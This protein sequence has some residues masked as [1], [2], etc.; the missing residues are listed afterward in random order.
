MRMEKSAALTPYVATQ[1]SG[2]Y[3]STQFAHPAGSAMCGLSTPPSG[4]SLSSFFF[5]KFRALSLLSKIALPVFKH[6]RTLL[7]FSAFPK[8]QGLY[9]QLLLHSLPKNTR[10][11]GYALH[12]T[13]EILPTER[14]MS[15]RINTCEK[16]LSNPSAINTYKNTRLKVER[17]QHLQK[18]GV[19]VLATLTLVES[20]C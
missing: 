1:T 6:L 7:H 19:G 12:E 9:F 11:G 2:S 18:K 20:I 15:R 13:L 14:P 16:M 5:S 4:P 17:N 8:W 3:A 10:G